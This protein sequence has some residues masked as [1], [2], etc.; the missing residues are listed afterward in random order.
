MIE[1][2]QY[3][4]I[5]NAVYASLLI[6]ILC[7]LVGTYVVSRRIVFI[8]GGVTHASFGGIGIGY[9]LGIHPL[10][11][12][13]VFSTIAANIMHY[14]T[15]S[16]KLREDSAIGILWSFGMALGIIFIFI[17]PGTPP[18]LMSYLFGNLLTVSSRELLMML[19][20]AIVVVL[21]FVV[22]YRLM[23]AIAFDESY[24]KSLRLPV[25]FINY[26]L[27]TLIA[28]VIVI[29]IKAA[30]IILVMSYL[31]IPQS[32]SNLFFN[33]FRKIA[34]GSIVI[35]L[36]G[37]VVGLVISYLLN[38]PTGA[39]VITVFVM[40]FLVARLVTGF[41]NKRKQDRGV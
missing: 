25:H 2:L 3:Q 23:I 7:G 37:S 5:Q 8:A 28:L 40:L 12:A 18:N 9:F 29:T 41:L 1:V 6:S 22:F 26:S 13:A 36:L 34:L 10:V 16:G 15:G 32:T 19:I 27:M 11:G 33:D 17:T 38:V 31:T 14:F 20:L 21:F 35:S 30:G 39:S 24:A 4:F